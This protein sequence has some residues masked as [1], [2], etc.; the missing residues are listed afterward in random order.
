MALV[1]LT[2]RFSGR[3]AGPLAM[4]QVLAPTRRFAPGRHAAD[5]RATPWALH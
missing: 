2:S 5:P 4:A 1:S 3:A